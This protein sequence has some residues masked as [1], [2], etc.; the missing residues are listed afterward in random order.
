MVRTVFDTE[1][2]ELAR[3]HERAVKVKIA[4]AKKQCM[5]A[6]K[7]NAKYYIEA[8]DF[9]QTKGYLKGVCTKGSALPADPWKSKT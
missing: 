2:A 7:S 4:N 5:A 1:E 9:L 8:R 6:F 3:L